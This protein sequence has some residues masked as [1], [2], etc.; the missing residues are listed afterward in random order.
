MVCTYG[1]QINVLRI[2]YEGRRKKKYIEIRKQ[3]S[4]ES[5]EKF[6]AEIQNSF[7]MSDEYKN[8]ESIF[9][10]VSMKNEVST[11]EVINR[12]IADGKT[13]AVPISLKNRDMFFVPIKSLDG[14]VKTKLGVYEPDCGRECEIVPNEKSVLVVPGVAFDEDGHRMGYGG[15]YYDT[16][17]EKYNVKN[18]E[19][20][21]F[22]CQIHEKIEFEKHDKIMKMIITEKNI[23]RCV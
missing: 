20:F 21:A 13:V 15:G 17:I 8:A 18:T 14:L 12:A 19:A 22:E 10:Y 5:K 1:I 3:L 7:I 9:I 23:R 2:K 4:T 11:T 6:S 16:Y